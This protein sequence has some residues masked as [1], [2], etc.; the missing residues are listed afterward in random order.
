M[1]PKDGRLDCMGSDEVG[2]RRFT[3]LCFVFVLSALY[4]IYPEDIRT[5]QRRGWRISYVVISGRGRDRF[6]LS[7]PF[8]PSTYLFGVN[9]Q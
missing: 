8:P 2:G 9:G 4:D 5:A 3:F 1:G 6:P 7:C